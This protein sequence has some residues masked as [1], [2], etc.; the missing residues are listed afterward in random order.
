MQME[1]KGISVHE[2]TITSLEQAD[3]NVQSVTL[4]TGERVEVES[5]WWVPVREQTS[6][7][8]SV[9]ETFQLELD[10]MGLIKTDDSGQ[11]SKKGLYA[12]GDVAQMLPSALG[13]MT[14][15][16]AAAFSIVREWSL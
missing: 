8:K 2:G 6:L 4:H 1:D 16:N 10:E 11:T 15:G 13:A 12:V 5:L 9:I 7:E 14:D 3:G